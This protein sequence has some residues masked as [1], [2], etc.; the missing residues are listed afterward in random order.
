MITIRALVICLC[1]GPEWLLVIGE[2][3]KYTNLWVAEIHGGE[4][5]AKRVARD[6]GY[7]YN[8]QV[9]LFIS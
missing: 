5:V 6:M 9:R 7:N 2:N 3:T 1:F 4:E 8:G